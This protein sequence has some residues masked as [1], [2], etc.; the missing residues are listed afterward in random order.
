MLYESNFE[1]KIIHQGVDTLLTSHVIM[2]ADA[3]GKYLKLLNK[4]EDY[5]DFA[6]EKNKNYEFENGVSFDFFTFGKFHI[7]PKGMGRF[8]YI[9]M[10]D[11]ITIKFST[12]KH[13]A[14]NFDTP[15][16]SVEYRAKYLSILGYEKAYSTVLSMFDNLLASDNT[17]QLF[18]SQLM[19]IDLCTDIAGI[20]YTPMDKF[21]FQTNFK[22]EGHIEFIEHM[23][24]N[25]LTGFSFGKGD[26]MMRIY[27]KRLE[28]NNNASKLWLTK[29]WTMNGY[30]QNNTVPVWRHETQMRRPYLKRFRNG[31]VNDE[32]QYFFKML[33]N[34]WTFSF[35]KVNYVELSDDNVLKVMNGLLSPDALR[36]VFYRTKENNPSKV[37]LMS[38]SWKGINAP[39][40]TDYGKF[41]DTD[42]KIAKRFYKSFISTA[43]KAGNG[44]PMEV[45]NIM[46]SV[47]Y[48]L[49][50][51][52]GLSLH[53][54]G[55]NKLLS[56][57]IDNS[58][59]ITNNGF[60]IDRDFKAM[61]IKMYDGI[62]KR[63]AGLGFKEF[64][65]NEYKLA[66]MLNMTVDELQSCDLNTLFSYA[67]EEEAQKI[68]PI[69]EMEYSA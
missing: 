3:Y 49:S 35:S 19:R 26:Y 1:P 2:C 38:S 53:D 62:Y 48:E 18:K 37:W 41:N 44:D 51:L 66:A 11:D 16:I 33:P 43:Y 67:F 54:Y 42:H 30:P 57:F 45:L 4:L 23:Q 6:K 52:Y 34:L 5:K 47:Q 15:Q 24:Y 60:T 14:N 9:I 21:R 20:T 22:N 63:F 46:D 64:D 39:S 56:S 68:Q 31:S 29:L 50:E 40:P 17:T 36:Q 32:V 61:A 59:Y 65:R 7:L 8:K 58:Q 28:L 69:Y 55:E 27:D 25:R 13:G 12:V 10:N